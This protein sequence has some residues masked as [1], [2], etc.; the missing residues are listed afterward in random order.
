MEDPD[1]RMS[2]FGSRMVRTNTA[3]RYLAQVPLVKNPAFQTPKPVTLNANY[4]KL[5]PTLFSTVKPPKL[6]VG[7]QD[8][9]KW[10]QDVDNLSQRLEME[11]DGTEIAKFESWVHQQATKVAPGLAET[12]LV[13]QPRVA[14]PPKPKPDTSSSQINELDQVFGATHLH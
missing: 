7:L 13:M 10:K 3:N 11:N 2:C 1:Q 5:I 12:P 14:S 8:I 4:N 6:N 9:N